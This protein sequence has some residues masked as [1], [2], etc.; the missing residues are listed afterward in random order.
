[1]GREAG[2]D[3]SRRTRPSLG[4]VPCFPGRRTAVVLRSPVSA[5]T[6]PRQASVGT[7]EGDMAAAAK[8]VDM[9]KMELMKEVR[10]HQ[11]AIGELNN[12]P[13]SRAA[14]Q[15]TCNIFFR[16]DITSPVASQQKQLDIAKAK[17]QKLD[18]A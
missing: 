11:V 3:E 8:E 5:A 7:A 17:L 13:P 18:Q 14:Y 12:L 9:K 2:P 16:K 6:P 4:P 1:M 15:K 10:A